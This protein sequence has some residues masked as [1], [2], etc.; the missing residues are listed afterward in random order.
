MD[1]IYASSFNS[2]AYNGTHGNL[3]EHTAEVTAAGAV[4]G[5]KLMLAKFDAGTVFSRVQLINA[6]L[7]TGVTVDLGLEYPDGEVAD[8]FTQF[9]NHAM[10]TAGTKTWEGKPVEALKNC[11]L[12]ATVKG[13]T[14]SGELFAKIQYQF[15]GVG[16]R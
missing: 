6:A 16:V 1:E 7:G 14:A 3:S 15:R 9:G 2:T 5:K 8:N 13:G 12:V 4:I 10:A 11:Y